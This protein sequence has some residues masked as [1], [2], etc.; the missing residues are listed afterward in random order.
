MITKKKGIELNQSFGAVLVVVLVAVLVIIAIFLFSILGDTFS[1]NSEVIINESIVAS[2][3]TL[4]TLSGAASCSFQSDVAGGDVY[5]GTLGVLLAT[6]NYTI[7]SNGTFI[8]SGS[9]FDT[10][11]LLVSYNFTDGG[12]ACNATDSMIT[13]FATYPALIGLVGTIVFLGLVIG[14]LVVSFVFGGKKERP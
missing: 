8:L 3:L 6:G 1:G 7:A 12:A 10:D 4:T 13:Q 5:N 14:I 11:T 2:N 9:E